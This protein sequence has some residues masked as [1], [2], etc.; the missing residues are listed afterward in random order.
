MTDED[1]RASAEAEIRALIEARVQAVRGK[2]VDG[3]TAYFS[4]DVVSFDVVGPLYRDG[5]AGVRERAAEWFGSFDGPI[6]YQVGEVHVT[7]GDDV[8]FAHYL[9]RVS[10]TLKAGGSVEMWVR[11]TLCCARRSGG[12]EIVHEHQSVPFDPATGR[13]SLDLEP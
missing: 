4:A 9:Y 10:A 6:G 8:A 12:W 1:R 2:D 11:T 3:A 7:A 5:A 13:A